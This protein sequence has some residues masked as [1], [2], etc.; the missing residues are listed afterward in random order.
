MIYSVLANTVLIVHGLFI[1]FVVFGGLL[2][3]R[4]PQ[5]MWLHV[6]ALTWGATVVSMG[7]ICPLTPLENTL[8]HMAGQQGYSGGF[9][10]HYLMSV[11]YPDGLTRRTQIL[12]AAVL[13]IGNT[14]VYSLLVH[15]F[16]HPPKNAGKRNRHHDYRL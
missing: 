14:T 10:E 9:I 1:G 7:W 13:I 6:P 15:R 16:R 11:I 2:V 8:R 3:L 12:L 5:L 4:Y